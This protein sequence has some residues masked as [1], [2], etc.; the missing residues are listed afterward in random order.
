MVNDRLEPTSTEK[1]KVHK[2]LRKELS[3]GAP[4]CTIVYEQSAVGETRGR[5][6]T[7]GRKRVVVEGMVSREGRAVK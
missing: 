6:R 4:L 3:E 7:Q 5:K 1:G 2:A